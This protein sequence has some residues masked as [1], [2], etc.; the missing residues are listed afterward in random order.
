[1]LSAEPRNVSITS[2]LREMMVS[3]MA[4]PVCSSF[5]T[6]SPPRRLRSTTSDL[7]VARRV[8]FTSSLRIEMFSAAC[9]ETCA[10]LSAACAETWLSV[11][12]AC[13]EI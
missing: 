5:C 3:V 11:S 8:W 4:E 9:A 12:A 7:P 13:A 2:S 6:T 10:R 1:M